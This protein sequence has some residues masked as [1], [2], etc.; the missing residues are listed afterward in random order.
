MNY[1]IIVVFLCVLGVLG[2]FQAI[3]EFRP[4]EVP[5]TAQN[6]Y[7]HNANI[8]W[9]NLQLAVKVLNFM[10][11]SCLVVAPLTF[12]KERPA[13]KLI[14]VSASHHYDYHRVKRAIGSSKRHLDRTSS[15]ELT[16]LFKQS[17]QFNGSGCCRVSTKMIYS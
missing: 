8:L 13:P 2:A 5:R 1:L 9:S 3:F 14:T 16:F 6:A 12:G 7:E 11:S 10:Y 17:I 15:S 4:L